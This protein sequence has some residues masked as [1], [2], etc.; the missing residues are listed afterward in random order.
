MRVCSALSV[1]IGLALTGRGAAVDLTTIDRSIRKEPAYQ[2][3]APQYCLL[4]FGPQAKTRVWLVLDGDALYLDRNGNGDLTDPGE[5]LAPVHALHRSEI[6]PDAEVLRTFNAED[7]GGGRRGSH[8]GNARHA[9]GVV[10]P[11]GAN[12]P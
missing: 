4:V 8:G 10:G 9:A 5:R 1:V 7:T 6:R 12:R 2:S 11:Y 3:K